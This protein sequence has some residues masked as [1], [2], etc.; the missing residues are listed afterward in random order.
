MPQRALNLAVALVGVLFVL[1]LVFLGLDIGR[2]AGRSPWRQRLLTAG[3]LLLASFGLTMGCS[4]E[5]SGN[6]TAGGATTSSTTPAESDLADTPQWKQLTAAWR[7][8]EEIA[9]GSRGGYPFTPSGQ[10]KVLQSLADAAVSAD[11]LQRAGLLSSPEAGLLKEDLL[12]LTKRVKHFRTTDLRGATCYI[13]MPI[14]TAKA[15]ADRLSA[16][17]PL[18]EKL[19]AQQTIHPEVV[20]KTLKNL[21]ADLKDVREN[22]APL[23]PADRKQANQVA[24]DV[25]VQLGKIRARM[26]GRTS[27][28]DDSKDWQII[29]AAWKEATPLAVTGTS[30]TR[31]RESAKAKLD[32]ARTAA[33]NLVAARL[34]TGPEGRLI[35]SEADQLQQDIYRNPPTDTQVSCYDMAYLP[36]ARQSLDRIAARLS[37]LQQLAQG[38]VVHRTAVEKVVASVEADLKELSNEKDL[39]ALT[40][41][42]RLQAQQQCADA[43]KSLAQIESLW[44][45]NDAA[46]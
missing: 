6:N 45:P 29:S 11:S 33:A 35:L 12:V 25:R 26:S 18:L 30:T 31:Q 21:E 14:P 2:V 17:L 34:I 36:P 27:A 22:K 13:P 38:G 15:S 8:A 46:Q 16:R 24:R 23:S 19:A 1:S 9:S 40:P 20:D 37:L 4:R 43:R 5:S 7:E 39:A 32:A 41:A 28:L 3:V 44:T 10:K 42:Q